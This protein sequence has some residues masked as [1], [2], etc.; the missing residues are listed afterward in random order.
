MHYLL[1]DF[2]V[3]YTNSATFYLKTNSTAR[4]KTVWVYFFEKT[5]YTLTYS[6]EEL[7]SIKNNFK[8]KYLQNS[9]ATFKKL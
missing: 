7:Q 1:H 6:K 4:K 2:K 5:N 8:G 3:G 9:T